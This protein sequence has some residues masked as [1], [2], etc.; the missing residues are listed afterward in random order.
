MDCRRYE[1][2]RKSSGWLVARPPSRDGDAG[3][4]ARGVGHHQ[5]SG[6]RRDGGV[7]AAA[8]DRH[9][10]IGGRSGACATSTTDDGMAVDG[11]R[12]NTTVT[13]SPRAL[14]MAH[15]SSLSTS[16]TI[17]RW[18]SRHQPSGRLPITFIPSTIHRTPHGTTA[19]PHRVCRRR[20]CVCR[21]TTI[22]AFGASSA[23]AGTSGNAPARIALP[24]PQGR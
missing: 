12:S 2:D 24:K 8:V 19:P 22:C 14:V 18:R 7:R 10:V 20:L 21:T 5:G 13:S 9:P 23:L 11:G 3:G 1:R 16:I 17:A 4:K 6:R 15:P